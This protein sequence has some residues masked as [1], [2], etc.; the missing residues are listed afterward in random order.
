[1]NIKQYKEVTQPFKLPDNL[2]AL[3]WSLP[4]LIDKVQEMLEHLLSQGTISEL[5][6]NMRFAR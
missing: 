2:N 3:T 5:H 4:F 1:M 6:G